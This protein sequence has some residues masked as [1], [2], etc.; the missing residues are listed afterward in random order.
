MKA[1]CID[2]KQPVDY[3]KATGWY[4]CENCGMQD[5]ACTVCENLGNICSSCKD[6]SWWKDENEE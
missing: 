3:D 2:C 1:T 6:G 5:Y 4:N